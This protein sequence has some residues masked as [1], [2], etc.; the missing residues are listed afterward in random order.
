L[1]TVHCPRCGTPNEPGD[2]F[3]S[4]CGASLEPSA[5]PVE[6]RSARDRLSRVIGTTRRARLVSIAT[7]VAVAAAVAAFI[8]LK[9]S[10]HSIP[11]DAYTI[12]ADRLCLDA[13]GEIISAEQRFGRPG[14]RDTSAFAH[15]LVPIVEAWR[16]KVGK[17]A[18]PP[19]RVELARELEAALLEA[20]IQIAALARVAAKGN[21]KVTLVS[22]RRAD[23]ASAGVE[24]AV[25]ALGLTQ[26]ANA[27]IGFSPA[28]EG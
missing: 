6:R 4:A 22:A 18:V 23:A 3:C 28:P 7:A 11:R 16:S 24:E 26:C 9:P 1:A 14:T 21:E 12:A 20:E 27:T 19:D 10:G 15:E 17:L 2:R 25:A 8:A 13:K 5:A